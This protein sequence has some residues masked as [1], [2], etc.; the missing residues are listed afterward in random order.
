MN[1]AVKFLLIALY[2][3]GTIFFLKAR[4]PLQTVESADFS[5]WVDKFN[6]LAVREKETI[7]VNLTISVPDKA[8]PQAI[9]STEI[10]PGK[11]YSLLYLIRENNIIGKNCRA[12]SYKVKIN[13]SS[14]SF[15]GCFNDYEKNIRLGNLLKL[16][17]HMSFVT[18]SSI[19]AKEEQG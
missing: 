3:A 2:I 13:S 18:A 6:Q 12:D 5:V 8:E 15:T 17:E 14:K 11:I 1:T 4:V 10:S 19:K 9:S 16:T 7:D